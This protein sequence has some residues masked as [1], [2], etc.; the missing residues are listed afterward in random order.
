[1]IIIDADNQILGRLASYVA[2]QA[3][4]GEVVNVVNAEKAIITGNKAHTLERFRRKR[5]LG[6]P[7]QGPYFIRKPEMIVKRTIRG[8]LP[9]KQE[10]GRSALKRIMCFRGIPDKLKG[11]EM[12]K[13]P[14]AD[15][16]RLTKARHMTIAEISKELGAKI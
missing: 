9:Y 4:L 14:G 10:K 2:K 15:S 11:K 5:N 7:L 13:V 8:M 6:V 3:L 16:S 12:H 1:M